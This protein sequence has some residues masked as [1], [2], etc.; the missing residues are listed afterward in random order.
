MEQAI[1][2]TAYYQTWRSV[3]NPQKGTIS[4][5]AVVTAERIVK[6]RRV[7]GV[8]TSRR[9]SASRAHTQPARHS[10][11]IRVAAHWLRSAQRTSG[12]KAGLQMR[13]R[14]CQRCEVSVVRQERHHNAELQSTR[15]E[16]STQNVSVSLAQREPHACERTPL[17]AQRANWQ[18]VQSHQQ[19]GERSSLLQRRQPPCSVVTMQR[20]AVHQLQRG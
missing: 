8:L 15:S 17:R 18:E 11:A 6:Q 14:E 5:H 4:V 3:L 7:S 2:C 19:K 16:R 10:A 13:E 12:V 1:S 20:S 9:R